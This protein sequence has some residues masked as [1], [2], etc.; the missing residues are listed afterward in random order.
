MFGLLLFRVGVFGFFVC[1]IVVLSLGVWVCCLSGVWVFIGFFFGWVGCV[2]RWLV[3]EVWGVCF[4]FWCYLRGCFLLNMCWCVDL[5]RGV[6]WCVCFDDMGC[7][8][9]GR[10]G[11]WLLGVFWF[12]TG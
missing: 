6:F 3:C 12:G 5:W 8:G 4:L 7:V 1:G 10:G 9:F 2:V 11:G